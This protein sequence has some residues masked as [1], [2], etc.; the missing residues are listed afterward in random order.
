MPPKPCR[1]QTRRSRCNSRMTGGQPLSSA[2]QRS[3]EVHSPEWRPANRQSGDWRTRISPKF[4]HQLRNPG[5][6][7]LKLGIQERLGQLKPL[8]PD[9]V[10][11]N[12]RHIVV[13]LLRKPAFR[14]SAED[15]GKPHGHFRRNPTLPI[16]EFGQRRAR[17]T[18]R[19]SRVLDRQA[20]RLNALAQHKAAGVWWILHCHRSI[21]R[22]G[23]QYSRRPRLR[24]QQNEKMLST[25]RK[26]ALS[27]S[28]LSPVEEVCR[29]PVVCHK[30]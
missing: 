18:E 13:R 27:P 10:G 17:D 1:R 19:G 4:P 20:Q 11:A 12:L 6:A 25:S 2:G 15:L 7:H 3:R 30:I 22:N 8:E 9:P 28:A 21:S 23:K 5:L 14:V 16:H 29:K 24:D 26:L